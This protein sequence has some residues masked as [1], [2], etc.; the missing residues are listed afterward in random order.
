M[1]HGEEVNFVGVVSRCAGVVLAHLCVHCLLL[2]A[3]C[4][5]RDSAVVSGHNMPVVVQVMFANHTQA[6]SPTD[7]HSEDQPLNSNMIRNKELHVVR[8]FNYNNK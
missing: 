2:C 1:A 6:R 8:E 3:L 4:F 5:A 7:S